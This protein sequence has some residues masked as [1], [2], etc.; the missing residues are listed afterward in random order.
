LSLLSRFGRVWGQGRTQK[1][2]EKALPLSLRT[3]GQRDRSDKSPPARLPHL[4]KRVTEVT[5]VAPFMGVPRIEGWRVG[6][7][8]HVRSDAPE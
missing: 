1:K 8:W 7:R 2:I 3:R 4:V 5:E 6:R